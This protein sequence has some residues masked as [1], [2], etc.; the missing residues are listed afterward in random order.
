MAVTEILDKWKLSLESDLLP[1]KYFELQIFI[2]SLRKDEVKDHLFKVLPLTLKLLDHHHIPNRFL[3]LKCIDHIKECIRLT[4]LKNNG[5]DML[6]L[7][8]LKNGLRVDD[9]E[10]LEE[11]LPIQLKFLNDFK[12]QSTSF[13]DHVDE[14]FDL[15]LV[16]MELTA[17]VNRK[18]VY[19]KNMSSYI[20]FLDINCVKYS[21]RIV[22]LLEDQLSFPLQDSVREMF[23]NV[24]RS[25]YSFIRMAEPRIKHWQDNLLF[26][27][28]KF[29]H[30]NL[31][32]ISNDELMI[33]QLIK[34]LE[35][36]KKSDEESFLSKIQFVQ[37]SVDY[38]QS[39]LNLLNLLQLVD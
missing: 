7:H 16:N 24:I 35:L 32:Q 37:N 38:N 31:D 33:N 3:G 13:N 29:A 25:T 9:D 8:T 23:T 36:L 27:L 20:E 15:I 34:T 21:K 1:V 6:L 30:S 12:N 26:I 11:L 28:L 17:K 5:M 14:T 18:R 4:E 2:C 10:Y 39:I 22:S 19:W